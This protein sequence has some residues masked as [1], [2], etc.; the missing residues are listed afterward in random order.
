LEESEDLSLIKSHSEA[1]IAAETVFDGIMKQPTV[2]Y[3]K[4]LVTRL[5]ASVAPVFGTIASLIAF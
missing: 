4:A 1:M 2:P 3:S 5:A